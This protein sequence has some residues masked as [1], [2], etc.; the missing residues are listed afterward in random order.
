MKPQTINPN[1]FMGMNKM[2][3]V[4]NKNT[5]M[6]PFYLIIFYLVLE[7]LR[8]QQLI[9]ILKYLHLPAL[10]VVLIL[11]SFLFSVKLYYKDVQTVLFLL[12]LTEMVVHG[13][14]AVN[15]YWAFQ[16]FY[17]MTITFIAYLGIINIIDT[18]YKYDK[19][20]GIWLIIFLFLSII[21]ALNKGIGV[22]GF[23]GDENDLAMSTNMVLPFGVFAMFSAS[24]KT[25][26]FYYFIL[27]CIF[28]SSILTYSRGGFVG[29]MATTIYCWIRTKR[30]IA[31]AAIIGVF[32]IF[33]LN[34]APSYYWERVATI[35]SEAQTTETQSGT[36][37]Q[38]VYSWKLGWHIFLENPII[39]VGQGNYP[40]TVGEAEEDAGVLWKTRSIS[41]RAAHSLYF[42]LLPELGLI[43]TLIFVMMIIY[44]LKDLKFIRKTS[45]TSKD[46]MSEEEAKKVYYLALA[47]EG[48]LV[49]FLTSSVFISTLYYPNFWILCGFILSLKKIIVAKKCDLNGVH[50]NGAIY[51]S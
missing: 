21:G 42:T 37:S 20:I 6:F 38:R 3:G 28:L 26:K 17:T 39:G 18:D 13:P 32:A 33:A 46:N 41:G 19:L 27:V 29:L 7:Y 5:T 45:L 2:S 40:W 14:I 34:V 1:N 11:V 15:N 43:G 9:P 25:S 10:T 4:V 8:P 12:L 30:K 36:G 49:A 24:K 35:S 16:M 50:Q 44:S 48:S 31:F 47:L 51:N 23:I 22:G